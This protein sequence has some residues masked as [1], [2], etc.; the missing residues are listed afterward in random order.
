MILP[1]SLLINDIEEKT[2]KLVKMVEKY[3]GPGTAPNIKISFDL[4]SIKAL[5]THQIKKETHFIRLN[6]AMLNELKEKYID[7]VFVHEFAHACVHKY[8][9]K[10]NNDKKILPHGREFKY[11]CHLFGIPGRAV[12]TIANNSEV[13]KQ[14]IKNKRKKSIKRNLIG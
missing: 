12:T 13:L 2:K 3:H 11:F 9:G 14:T 6:A 7:V 1:N 10:R 4:N 5:G 8:Y